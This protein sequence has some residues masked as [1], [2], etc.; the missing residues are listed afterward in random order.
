MKIENFSSTFV[1][2]DVSTNCLYE[3]CILVL[4]KDFKDSGC[5]NS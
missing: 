2:I 3:R 1:K 4:A 5:I